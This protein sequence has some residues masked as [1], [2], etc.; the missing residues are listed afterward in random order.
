MTSDLNR[1]EGDILIYTDNKDFY[2]TPKTLFRQL[3]GNQRYLGGKILD[4]SAGK[5]ERKSALDG[6]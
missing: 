6:A 1:K 3:V 4:P 2:P 5:G